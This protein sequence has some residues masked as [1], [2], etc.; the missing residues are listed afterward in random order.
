MSRKSVEPLFPIKRIVVPVDGSDNAAR[1][2]DAAIRIAKEQGAQLE[3]LHVVTISGLIV[4]SPV[5]VGTPSVNL[6][7]YYEISEKEGRKLVDHVVE[8]AKMNGVEARGEVLRSVSS[9]AY[10]ITENAKGENADLIV[11]GTRGLGGFKKLLLGSVSSGVV[12][13]AH[14]A[15]LVI[16]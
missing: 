16:R 10:A 9:P 6:S 15:V 11:I 1:A 4:S 13:H 8:R 3:V 7:D 14:C 2:G 5:G 12:T